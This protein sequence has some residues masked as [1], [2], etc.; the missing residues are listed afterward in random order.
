MWYRINNE[1]PFV[2]YRGEL[3]LWENDGDNP[4]LVYRRGEVSEELFR[5]WISRGWAAKTTM[6]DKKV[7]VPLHH[8]NTTQADAPVLVART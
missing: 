1:C 8:A 7:A 4:R 2:E 6:P 3:M 5:E